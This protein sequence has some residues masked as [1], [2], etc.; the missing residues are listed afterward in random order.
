MASMLDSLD[1]GFKDLEDA[2]QNFAAVHSGL[3]D[4]IVTRNIKDYKTRDLAVFT[5]KIYLQSR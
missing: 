5:P 4:I 1:S 2:M 3:A